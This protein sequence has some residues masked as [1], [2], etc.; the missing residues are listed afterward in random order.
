MAA[1]RSLAGDAASVCVDLVAGI[2]DTPDRSDAIRSPPQLTNRG[3]LRS[4]FRLCRGRERH[5]PAI[6]QHALQ[7][8]A[9]G[10][11]S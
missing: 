9:A 8:H 7:S 10:L 6:G 4:F 1:W 5:R 2:A 11:S 3:F